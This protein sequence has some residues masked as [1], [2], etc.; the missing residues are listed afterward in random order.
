MAR[1]DFLQKILEKKKREVQ[2][3]RERISEQ[4]LWEQSLDAGPRRGF[5]RNL[6]AIPEAGVHII[7]EIKRASPSKGVLRENL[8]ASA[9]AR[10]YEEG[11]ASAISVLTDQAFFGA[12]EDDLKDAR[13]PVRLPVLRKDFVISTYQIFQ[14]AVMG[15]DAILL[16]AAALSDTF[17]REAISISRETGLDAL[18]ETHTAEEVDR[19]LAAGAEIVGI[20]NRNLSTFETDINTCIRLAE[21]IP[22]GKVIVAES[23]IR[24]R[25][26]ILAVQKAGIRCFLIGESLVKSDDPKKA[27]AELLGR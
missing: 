20:N 13:R 18:V 1:S 25:G 4:D 23:G 15:A 24:N 10:A 26:D 17:L 21:K 27:L 7:A 9:Q 22:A 5:F 19:A 2:K 14:S 11:G 3:A 12:R 6:S 8:D 16:I